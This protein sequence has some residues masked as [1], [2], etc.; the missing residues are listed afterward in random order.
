MN[1]ASA[2]VFA[3]GPPILDFKFCPSGT[4]RFV[5]P[6]AS[7]PQK[8]PIRLPGSEQYLNQEKNITKTNSYVHL[9]RSR[10]DARRV[11][12]INYGF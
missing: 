8:D 5:E 9:F 3:P 12:G 10:P 2:W 6:G 11:T 4:E 1:A 7:A